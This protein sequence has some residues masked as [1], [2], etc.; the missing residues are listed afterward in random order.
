MICLLDRNLSLRRR[1]LNHANRQDRHGKAESLTRLS[2][3]GRN[4]MKPFGKQFGPPAT[5]IASACRRTGTAGQ[6]PTA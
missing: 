5:A 6:F 2:Q 1:P 3:R 4:L